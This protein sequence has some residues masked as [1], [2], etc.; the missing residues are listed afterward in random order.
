MVPTEASDE[1]ASKGMEFLCFLVDQN[2]LYDTAIG[3]YDLD[4]TL[5]VAR[6][7]AHK[8]R[9]IAFAWIMSANQCQDP[10][11]YMPFLEDLDASSE[12]EMKFKIDDYLKRNSKALVHLHN[13]GDHEAVKTYTFKHALFKE[14]LDIYKY[15]AGHTK[16]VMVGYA[17]YLH[18]KHDYAKAAISRCRHSDTCGQDH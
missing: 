6:E 9:T 16:D 3:L 11:E 5:R 13:L 1:H 18:S 2:K 4:L 14:A 8:V 15:N 12:D 17:S 7:T 10:R